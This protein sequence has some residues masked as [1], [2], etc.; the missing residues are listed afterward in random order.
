M[1][2]AAAMAGAP[3]CA[4]GNGDDAGVGETP[5]GDAGG[6]APGTQ[7]GA[8]ADAD[9]GHPSEASHEDGG[10]AS[11]ASIDAD[12]AID[13][14]GGT[15]D[16]GMDADAS[17][18]DASDDAA[19]ATLDA[20]DGGIVGPPCMWGSGW[21]AWRFHYDANDGTNAILDVYSLPD[22]SNWEAVPAF[23]TQFDDG[24]HGGGLSLGSGNW[25]LI[26]YSVAG[27]TQINGA[28]LT[29]YGRSYDVSASGSYDAWAPLYGDDAAPTDSL[30]NAWPYSSDSIDFTG[31]VHVGDD[32]NL[33]GIRLY[34]GPSS[35]SLIVNTVELCI[36]GF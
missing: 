3:A 18:G 9:S 33:T 10:A 21:T 29:V 7:D 4:T 32:P 13:A 5:V 35:N 30:S 16:D 11:D 27:L 24:L 19:D 23:P 14:D 6:D 26:R 8:A 34:S 36:D 2:A 12:A 28:T 17:D 15:G 22:N 20:S 31:S 1:A 25:I